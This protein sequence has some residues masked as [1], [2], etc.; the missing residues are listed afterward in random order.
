[1]SPTLP[2]STAP[3]DLNGPKQNGEKHYEEIGK[4]RGGLRAEAIETGQ[5][6]VSRIWQEEKK[7][8]IFLHNFMTAIPSLLTAPGEEKDKKWRRNVLKVANR[9][10]D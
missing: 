3:K 8:L 10:I 9:S 7:C 1:M 2:L 5:G 4:E 6:L